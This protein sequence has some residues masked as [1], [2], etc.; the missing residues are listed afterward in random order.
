MA[1]LIS[2]DK[3]RKMN[4]VK[5]HD[6]GGNLYLFNIPPDINLH[7]K[8]VLEKG[9]LIAFKL[10]G[11]SC[12]NI[13]N[14]PDPYYR[15]YQ[16]LTVMEFKESG[17][18]NLEC[19]QLLLESKKK[20]PAPG[21][22]TPYPPYNDTEELFDPSTYIESIKKK[23]AL[24]GTFNGREIYQTSTE[25]PFAFDEKKCYKCNARIPG[26]TRATLTNG[27][28]SRFQKF[29]PF[30]SAQVAAKRSKNWLCGNCLNGVSVPSS[31]APT[32]LTTPSPEMRSFKGG[33]YFTFQEKDGKFFYKGNEITKNP[34][35]AYYVNS[36]HS[37]K[38]CKGPINLRA[39]VSFHDGLPHLVSSNKSID[40]SARPSKPKS[41]KWVHITCPKDVS[42][43]PSEPS[44]PVTQEIPVV[45]PEPTAIPPL[46][47]TKTV[48]TPFKGVTPLQK[49]LFT[50]LEQMAMDKGVDD[51]V[52]RGAAWMLCRTIKGEGDDH[53]K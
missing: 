26:K 36:Q 18:T 24:L 50:I 6:G 9:E 42:L 40:S 17:M 49:D 33:L 8:D 46:P 51:K 1:K 22:H 4:V 52:F 41:N 12:K 3:N 53:N 19:Q 27:K 43:P 21:Q 2:V 23:S 47:A 32:D 31:S 29:T 38:N 48:H 37:C 45:P 28:Y 5:L 30:T 16:H 14:S 15:N 7:M 20:A 25:H 10:K 11:E 34:S 44:P 39:S 35:G 13:D